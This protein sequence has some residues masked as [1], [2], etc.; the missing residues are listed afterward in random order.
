MWPA[1]KNLNSLENHFSEFVDDNV[2]NSVNY[3]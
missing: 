3:E 2:E 1:H